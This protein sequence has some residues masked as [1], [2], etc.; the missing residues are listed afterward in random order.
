[1]YN[2]AAACALLLKGAK[3]E[4]KTVTADAARR[5]LLQAEEKKRRAR[6]FNLFYPSSLFVSCFFVLQAQSSEGIPPSPP[7]ARHI[8]TN[9]GNV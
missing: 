3:P 2:K 1:M 4:G 7:P 8:G 6:T 5:A 9:S